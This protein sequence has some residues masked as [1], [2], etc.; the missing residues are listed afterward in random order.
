[1]I[2]P[3]IDLKDRRILVICAKFFG[4]EIKVVEHLRSRGALVEFADE[5]PG[6]SSLAKTLIR[7]HSVIIRPIINKYYIEILKRFSKNDFD[8]ILFISPE[9]CSLKI[10]QLF[11]LQYPKARF[12]LYMWD[13]LKNKGHRTPDAFLSFFDRSLSFDDED[14]RLY[15]LIFRPLFFIESM[16]DS[17]RE[18]V[19]YAFSFVGTIHSDRFK[20]IRTFSEEADKLGLKYFVYPFLPSRFHYWLYRLTKREFQGFS[21]N[22]FHFHPMPYSEVLK[23]LKKSNVIIDM[24]HPKQRGLTMR[25]LEVLGAGKKLIT[26]NKEIRC[27]SFFSEDRV[28]IIDRKKPSLRSSFFEDNGNPISSD[29]ISRFS[30]THWVNDIFQC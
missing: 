5:R 17:S 6:N 25:T 4:Y 15:G 21:I 20:I 19:K 23:I 13:S 26:T 16:M 10:M 27:Y 1:M 29:V 12:L 3:K 30:I 7:L 11:R 8:D 18:K 28:M 24:E 22:H 14:S 2:P 9:C